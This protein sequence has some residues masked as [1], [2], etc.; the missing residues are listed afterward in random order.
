MMVNQFKH[1]TYACDKLATG[2][3]CI[4]PSAMQA[5]GKLPGT[6]VLDAYKY[7]YADG[8]SWQWFGIMLAIIVVY[9]IFG[10]G[11]LVMKTKKL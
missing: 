2:Y 10:Y 3:H 7:S 6:A 4:Y 8:K 5:E 9:R 11:V 1:T